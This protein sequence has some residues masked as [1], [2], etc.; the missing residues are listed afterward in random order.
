[1]TLFFLFVRACVRVCVYLRFSYRRRRA[2]GPLPA[3]VRGIC[4]VQPTLGQQ[5]GRVSEDHLRRGQPVC[6]SF[7]CVL[8]CCIILIFWMGL[9]DFRSFFRCALSLFVCFS[10]QDVNGCSNTCGVFEFQCLYF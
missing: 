4:W 7:V 10:L 2:F 9:P 3:L 8:D 1:M 6:V 5:Y